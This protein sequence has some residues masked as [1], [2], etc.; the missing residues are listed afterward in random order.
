MLCD[1]HPNGAWNSQD[2]LAKVRDELRAHAADCATC[3]VQ[4]TGMLIGAGLDEAIRYMQTHRDGGVGD[5][6][7]LVQT[8]LT[9]LR[10]LLERVHGKPGAT[11]DA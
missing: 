10:P 11:H 7:E 4:L 5:A 8:M 2:Q 1:Q 6:Y 9:Q 3:H